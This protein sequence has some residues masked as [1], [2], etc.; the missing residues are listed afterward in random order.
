[1]VGILKREELP[2]NLLEAI[3]QELTFVQ[4]MKD[5]N[6]LREPGSYSPIE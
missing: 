4:A 6:E 3:E 2:V 5:H 1:V